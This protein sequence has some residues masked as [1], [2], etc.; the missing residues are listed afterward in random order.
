V[1]GDGIPYRTVAGN[2]HPAAAYFTRGTGHDESDRY[3]E[4]P[5][6][7]EANLTRLKRKYDIARTL[8]PKPVIEKTKGATI[9]II[10]YGSTTPA[11]AEARVLLKQDDGPKSDTLRMRAL[12][13][14]AEV[15]EFV[16]KHERIYV[17]EANRDGQ[18]REILSATMP[19]QAGKFR[20]AAHADG[21]PLTA[22]WVK[23]AILAQEEK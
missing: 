14:T 1:D 13:C 2:K 10:T 19:D 20:S 16:K 4:D 7:W 8:V 15:H 3:T 23:D 12:P 11:V 9:G 6:P 21:L 17:V 22:K 5:R 18:L